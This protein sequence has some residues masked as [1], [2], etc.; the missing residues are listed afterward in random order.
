LSVQFAA[1]NGPRYKQKPDFVRSQAFLLLAIVNPKVVGSIRRGERPPL[2][3]KA[4]F[5]KKPG[6]FV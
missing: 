4:W 3:I 2:Q 6:F 5:H 1:A